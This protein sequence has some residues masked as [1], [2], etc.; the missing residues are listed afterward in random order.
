MLAKENY[1]LLNAQMHV[2]VG[3]YVDAICF[4]GPVIHSKL[5]TSNAKLYKNY[6]LHKIFVKDQDTLIEQSVSNFAKIIL[7]E[8]IL[9]THNCFE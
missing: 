4:Y 6:F 3:T 5:Q 2:R 9:R 8:N 7:H 1:N